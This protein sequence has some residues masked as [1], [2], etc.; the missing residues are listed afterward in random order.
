MSYLK[1]NQQSTQVG[2]RKAFFND[3][4][5]LDW[6]PLLWFCEIIV[7]QW[8]CRHATTRLVA[9]NGE[10]PPNQ[11]RRRQLSTL[12]GDDIRWQARV[13]TTNDIAVIMKEG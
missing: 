11:M 6:C 4:Q 5:T 9:C 13:F 3:F 1:E 10:R 7:E 12:I 8:S 2:D